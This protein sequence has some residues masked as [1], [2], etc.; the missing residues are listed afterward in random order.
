[1]L[2]AVVV[3]VNSD[4]MRA[5]AGA[6]EYVFGLIESDLHFDRLCQT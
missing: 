2:E 4:T 5:A 6:V 1:M 3:S